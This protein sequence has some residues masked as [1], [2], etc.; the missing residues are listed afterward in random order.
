MVTFLRNMYLNVSDMPDRSSSSRTERRVRSMNDMAR[1]PSYGARSK[2]VTTPA[3][4]ATQNSEAG[5]NTFQP[6]R[7]S[8]S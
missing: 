5:R 2:A 1:L 6:S 4:S 8:W 3:V 7:M